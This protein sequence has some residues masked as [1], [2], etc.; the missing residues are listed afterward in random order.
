MCVCV[1]V[2]G[3]KKA[4]WRVNS[5]PVTLLSGTLCLPRERVGKKRRV[6]EEMGTVER[7]LAGWRCATDV[8]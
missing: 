7:L 2:G 8:L 5:R 1:S 4:G 3:K 6:E